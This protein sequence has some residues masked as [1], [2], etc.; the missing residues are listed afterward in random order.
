ME[1]RDVGGQEGWSGLSMGDPVGTGMQGTL[2]MG[3]AV[4]EVVDL[5]GSKGDLQQ[6]VEEVMW[7]SLGG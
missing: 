4:E 1:R 7:G 2:D 5:H 3:A 6:V